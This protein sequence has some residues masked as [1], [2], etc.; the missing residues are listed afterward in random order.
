MGHKYNRANSNNER[1]PTAFFPNLAMANSTGE[2]LATVMTA[3]ANLSRAFGE[4]YIL[5]SGASLVCQGSQHV[6]MD[7]DVVVPI[8]CI[9]LIAFTLTLSQDV[10]HRAGVVYSRAGETEFPVDILHRIISGRSFEDLKP[11][12]ITILGG[13]KI[14]NVRISLGINI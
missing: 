7:L 14:L 5:I 10:T 13:I 3:V 11:F 4:K 12:T 2:R 9:D 1:T 8:E 6:T